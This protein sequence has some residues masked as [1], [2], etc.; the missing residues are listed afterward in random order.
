MQGRRASVQVEV[1]EF[2]MIMHGD[3]PRS[4]PVYKRKISAP[5]RIVR[6][7]EA[8][9]LAKK[10]LQQQ[11]PLYTTFQNHHPLTDIF[12]ALYRR[13]KGKKKERKKT[14]SIT[15][16]EPAL[17]PPHTW[18]LPLPLLSS[19]VSQ[20]SFRETI[21]NYIDFYFNLFFVCIMYI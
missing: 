16:L 6:T 7:A 3:R 21:F 17:S 20:L 1:M 4:S 14:I 9:F 19:P 12:T 2:Q 11:L 5:V 8:L 13:I 18:L 10:I 15:Q